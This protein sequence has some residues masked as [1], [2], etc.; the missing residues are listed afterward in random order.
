MQILITGR[1]EILVPALVRE[2]EPQHTVRLTNADLRDA[3][4][5]KEAVQGIDAIIHLLGIFPPQQEA[6]EKTLDVVLRGTYTLLKEAQAAGVRRVI[7]GSSLDLFA[8]YPA[9]YLFNESW[10]PR[11]STGIHDLCA[12]LTEESVREFA[13]TGPMQGVVLRMGAV[14]RSDS[15]APVALT[16]INVTDAVTAFDRAL[17]FEP[18]GAW[19]VFHIVGHDDQRVPL[20]AAAEAPFEFLPQLPAPASIRPERRQPQQIASR[21]IK[22]VVIFGAGGPIPAEVARALKDRYVLRL[23]D[24]RSLAEAAANPQSPTAPVPDPVESP[25][26]EMITDV[27]DYNQ[28]LAACEGIDAIVNG[29]VNRPHP[30]AAWLVNTLGAY[31]VMRAAV[32]SGIRRVVHTGPEL[33]LWSSGPWG[34]RSDFG[35][36]GRVPPRAGTAL[37]SHTKYLAQ[38]IVRIFAEEYGLEVPAFYFNS[39]FTPETAPR[40]T[41]S[42]RGFVVSWAD[43]GRSIAAGVDVAELPD[44]YVPFLIRGNIPNGKIRIDDAER[45]LG[46]KPQDNLDFMWRRE[47]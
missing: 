2:L 3:D 46:W 11:P 28:V 20:A 15:P 39:L 10:L 5:A 42:I 25:H 41:T 13:M 30:V 4:A 37:Y 47:V 6:D 12:Y 8:A 19:S 17:Y 29:T 1:D 33:V 9:D 23:T 22:R 35:L 43:A 26:E 38:E 36:T 44:P 27:T 45:I 16:A 14:V 32:A 31:N 24:I 7:V 18:D 40:A 21:P 34:Y